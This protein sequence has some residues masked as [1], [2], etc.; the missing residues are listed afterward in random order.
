[1]LD[2][3]AAM[4]VPM[5]IDEATGFVRIQ[6]DGSP[7]RAL[8]IDCR[9][10]PDLLPVLSTMATFA[11]GTTRLWNVAHIRL[12]ESDRVAAMLQ[13]NR[14]GGRAEQGSD[15]LRVTGVR[16]GELHGSPMS[17]FNDHRVLMSLAVA[18]SKAEGT[19]SLTYPRAYRISYP[20][21]LEAMNGVG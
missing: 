11:E 6:H 19:S 8:D 3:A 14:M 12:K 15:E 13:L 18:A 4:G 9:P 16:P 10:I 5:R 21:F 1:F 20:T 17:S 7:L 2:L